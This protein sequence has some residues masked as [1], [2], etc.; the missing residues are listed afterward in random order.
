MSEWVGP[1]QDRKLRSSPLTFSAHHDLP[2]ASVCSSTHSPS[3]YFSRLYLLRV[4]WSRQGRKLGRPRSRCWVRRKT[5]DF[6]GAALL[7]V[8]GTRSGSTFLVVF[9]WV[10][11]TCQSRPKCFWSENSTAPWTIASIAVEFVVAADWTTPVT[12]GRSSLSFDT[13]AIKASQLSP[14]REH[15]QESLCSTPSTQMLNLAISVKKTWARF[16]FAV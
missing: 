4:T 16:A 5:F 2:Q 12:L 14:T 10:S 15:D 3:F 7:S 6:L 11:P 9:A 1:L 8:D 13:E